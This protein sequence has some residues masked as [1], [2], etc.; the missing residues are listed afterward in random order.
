MPRLNKSFDVVKT[1]EQ[2]LKARSLAENAAGMQNRYRDLIKDWLLQWGDTDANGHR[3]LRF[4]DDPVEI[5]VGEGEVIT[6]TAIKAEKKVAQVFDEDAAWKLIENLPKKY[7]SKVVEVV[8]QIDE[9]ALLGLAFDEDVEEVTDE[10]VKALY[11][12]KDPTYAFKVV[13]G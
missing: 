6:V 2:H 9:D 12:K 4:E 5:P 3:W 8:E 10:A 11:A 7:R 1:L 13:K